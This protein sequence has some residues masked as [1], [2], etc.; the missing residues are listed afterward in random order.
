MADISLITGNLTVLGSTT[1]SGSSFLTSGY[2]NNPFVPSSPITRYL[3]SN[4]TESTIPFGGGGAFARGIGNAAGNGGSGIVILK[5]Q[6][7]A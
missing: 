7:Q 5:Y 4:G 2:T 3:L 6:Y 1:L